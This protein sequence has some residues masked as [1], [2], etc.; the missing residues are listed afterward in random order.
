[1][2]LSTLTRVNAFMLWN[3]STNERGLSVRVLNTKFELYMYV[4]RT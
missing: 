1:M 2:L 4:I 3:E